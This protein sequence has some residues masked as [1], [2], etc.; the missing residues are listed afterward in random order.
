MEKIKILKIEIRS[1]QNVGKAWISWKKNP[2][3]PIWGHPMPF[4]PWTE[5]I[6]KMLKNAYFPWWMAYFPLCK[7]M[8]RGGWFDLVKAL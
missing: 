1:A 4:S 8:Q 7:K 6:K 2:P 5:K 3:G